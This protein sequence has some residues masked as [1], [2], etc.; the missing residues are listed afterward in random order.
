MT[1]KKEVF[2]VAVRKT[3]GSRESR[4]LRAAGRIPAVLYGDGEQNISLSVAGDQFAAAIRH[5]AK[6]VQLQ[7]DV[8]ED[9]LISDIQWDPFGVTPLHADFRRVDLRGTVETE[10]TI[11]LRGEAPGTHQGGV[12]KHILHEVEIECPVTQI[13]E[14]LQLNINHLELDQ[15]LTLADVELP[16]GAKLLLDA[17]TPVVQ[18]TPAVEAPEEEEAPEPTGAEPEVIGRAA[19]GS[20]ESSED[21]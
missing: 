12:L 7:G 4:R 6:L 5:G 19:E 13:P 16:Q 3:L 8:S 1:T 15:T 10:V 20:E 17:S 21:A 18:C 11:E 2:D 9:V 14:V